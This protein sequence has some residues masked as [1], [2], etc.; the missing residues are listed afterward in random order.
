[1]PV[2]R[3]QG[4]SFATVVLGRIVSDYVK[5]KVQESEL[6][7]SSSRRLAILK[8]RISER[9]LGDI[10]WLSETLKR[11]ENGG[12]KPALYQTQTPYHQQRRRSSEDKF[13]VVLRVLIVALI[14]SMTPLG[15]VPSESGLTP[16]R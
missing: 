4:L 7:W 8:K 16:P 11:Q 12:Q 10:R 15:N 3:A 9:H 2:N 6:P 14:L 13:R 5:M 1:M